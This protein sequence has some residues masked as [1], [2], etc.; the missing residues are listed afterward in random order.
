MVADAPYF[1]DIADEFARFF[2]DAIFVAHNVDFDYRFISG[3]FARI[4]QVFR[5]PK[6]CTCASMRRLFSGYGSYSLAALCRQFNI[7]LDQHHRAL[8]DAEAAAGLL[9]LVNER[10]AE[11]LAA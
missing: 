1:A 7:P 2:G 4:G 9:L 11:R 8:C 6:L 3:E 5:H 10:R